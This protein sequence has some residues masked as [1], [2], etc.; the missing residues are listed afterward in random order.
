MD[1]KELYKID[2]LRTFDLNTVLDMLKTNKSFPLSIFRG[3][4]DSYYHVDEKLSYDP[5]TGII[6]YTYQNCH[7]DNCNC[8][9]HNRWMTKEITFKKACEY[10][11]EY[12]KNR[13]DYIKG[14]QDNKDRMEQ[15]VRMKCAE[16][17]KDQVSRA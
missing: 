5:Q 13:E 14:L 9:S 3:K 1:R 12:L 4:Q 11:S 15:A 7:S 6:E 17:G 16:C 10:L 2:D 8:I